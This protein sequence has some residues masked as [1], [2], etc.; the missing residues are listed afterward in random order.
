MIGDSG[1][2][3]FIS[4][5]MKYS[6]LLQSGGVNILDETKSD[7]LGCYLCLFGR[8]LLYVLQ[9]FSLSFIGGCVWSIVIT[10]SL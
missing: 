5:F 1:Y 4:F 10:S 6:D 9:Q 2:K 8:K 7:S 3:F